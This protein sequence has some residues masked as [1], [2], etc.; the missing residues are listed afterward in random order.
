MK[1]SSTLFLNQPHL[2]TFSNHSVRTHQTFINICLHNISNSNHAPV[3]TI[4]LYTTVQVQSEC[5]LSTT[6]PTFY[7]YTR[8]NTHPTPS[9]RWVT[10]TIIKRNPTSTDVDFSDPTMTL[11]CH[12][13]SKT[14]THTFLDPPPFSTIPLSVTHTTPFPYPFTSTRSTRAYLQF[15]LNNI[16]PLPP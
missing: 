7:S 10:G 8:K 1:L 12:H 13:R 3:T 4:H 6:T 2:Q 15:D 5:C 14:P 16:T 11:K 9:Q